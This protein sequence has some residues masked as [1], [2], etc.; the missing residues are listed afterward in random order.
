M[1]FNFRVVPAAA[2]RAD[3]RYV[4]TH[5]NDFI[6]FCTCWVFKTNTD[7]NSSN[8]SPYAIELRASPTFRTTTLVVIRRAVRLVFSNSMFSAFLTA[9]DF[10]NYADS[11]GYI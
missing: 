10:V 5:Y 8:V 4:S 2:E 6:V 7:R 1:Y 11:D 9:A 3:L